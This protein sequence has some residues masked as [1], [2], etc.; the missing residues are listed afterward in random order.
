VLLIIRSILFAAAF[1]FS[2]PHI[3]YEG[4]DIHLPATAAARAC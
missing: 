2:P 3:V 4:H 1:S